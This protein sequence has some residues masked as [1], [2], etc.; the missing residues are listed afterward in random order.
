[1]ISI[2][3]FVENFLSPP[4]FLRQPRGGKTALLNKLCF[5]AARF[6]S[7]ACS[8]RLYP[9][10]E[11]PLRL[12]AFSFHFKFGGISGMKYLSTVRRIYIYLFINLFWKKANKNLK[13]FK[14]Y[15][16]SWKQICAE[17][18]CRFTINR[19]FWCVPITFTFLCQK[20]EIYEFCRNFSR[21]YS[22]KFYYP[23]RK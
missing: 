11:S 18:C 4:L 21:L 14:I 15:R 5:S 17:I 23:N 10:S 1:M 20:R 22:M 7:F 16:L 2:I 9:Y 6:L 12:K 8:I 13:Y 3:T 19:I